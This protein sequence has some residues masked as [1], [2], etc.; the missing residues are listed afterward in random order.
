M[1]VKALV[2]GGEDRVLHDLGHF[3]YGDY[4]AAL[5]S[6]FTDQGAFRAVDPQRN[7]GPVIGE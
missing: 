2:F 1:L 7:L 6:E 5:L 4:G 3:A